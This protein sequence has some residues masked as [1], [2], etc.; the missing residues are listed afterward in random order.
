MYQKYY[1]RHM[2][3][4]GIIIA[5][6][7]VFAIFSTYFIYQNFAEK[8]NQGYDSGEMKVVFHEKQGNKISM[9]QF[10]PVTDAVGLSSTAYTFTVYNHT[11]NSV[12]YKIVLEKDEEAIAACGCADRQIPY[13][14][15]KLSLRKDHLAPSALVLSEYADGVLQTDTLESGGQ[16]D[17]SIR[18]WA[19]NSNFIVDRTSHFHAKIK[20]VEE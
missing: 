5:L 17:Y 11:Q 16:E 14:L 1:R 7:L 15:L 6:L 8:R 13:E 3:K 2:I 18:I 9:T 12:N 10:V 19:M 4:S 20:V